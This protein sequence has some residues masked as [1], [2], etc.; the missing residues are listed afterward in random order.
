MN[1]KVPHP[2]LENVEKTLD[3]NRNMFASD[4]YISPS[5]LVSKIRILLKTDGVWW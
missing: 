3:P 2:S 1:V 5:S 4:E